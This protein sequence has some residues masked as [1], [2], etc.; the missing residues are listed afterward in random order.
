MVAVESLDDMLSDDG[1]LVR[2][3]E[4]GIDVARL[5]VTTC[6]EAMNTPL[7]CNAA[8]KAA[9]SEFNAGQRSHLML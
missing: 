9:P 6:R 1:I 4:I 8:G 7:P 2:L 5:T 3:K